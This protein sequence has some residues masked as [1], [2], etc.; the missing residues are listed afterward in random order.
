MHITAKELVPIVM[1]IAMWGAEW[2][3]STVL[4]R[5]DNYA[6]VSSLSSGSAKDVTL[7]HIL[8]FY[9][10]QFDIR[11]V[12]RHIAGA[13][14]TAADALSRDNLKV[15]FQLNPQARLKCL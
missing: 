4:I 6:V 3:A 5:S 11:V 15:F 14:N 1:A 12:T 9:L 7:M 2:Q 10:A 13:E 8:H